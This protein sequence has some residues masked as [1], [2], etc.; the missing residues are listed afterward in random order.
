MEIREQLMFSLTERGALNVANGGP[1]SF[2]ATSDKALFQTPKTN[3]I[4][5]RCAATLTII[6]SMM[7]AGRNSEHKV[8]L[9]ARACRLGPMIFHP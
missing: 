4:F 9:Q 8:Q 2:L 6:G 7:L 3:E 1:A 5:K